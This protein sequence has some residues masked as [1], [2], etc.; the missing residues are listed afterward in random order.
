MDERI[1]RRAMTCGVERPDECC[2]AG[3]HDREQ[4]FDR[5]KHAGHT[6]EGEGGGAEAD[7]LAVVRR[8]V[9]PDDV[10][11]IGGGVDVIERAV[12]VVETRTEFRR[13][14]PGSRIPDPGREPSTSGT[15]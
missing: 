1:D 12:E 14:D 15:A 8:G 6:P 2:R 5:L 13:A 7:D 4:R 3:S 9:A 11:R 10:D